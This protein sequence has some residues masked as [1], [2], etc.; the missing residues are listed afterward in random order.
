MSGTIS[1]HPAITR[2]MRRALIVG[3][4]GV[5]YGD[6]GTSPKP[7]NPRHSFEGILGPTQ[8]ATYRRIGG[9]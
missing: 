5:V 2:P 6:I 9:E 3:A 1:A 4:L 8:P 7:N